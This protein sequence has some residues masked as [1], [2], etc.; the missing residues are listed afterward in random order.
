MCVCVCVCVWQP[1]VTI[2]MR[3][4]AMPLETT[5]TMACIS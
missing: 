3:Y 2:N 4:Y 1:G 5:Y